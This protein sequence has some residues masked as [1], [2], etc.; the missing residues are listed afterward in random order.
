MSNGLETCLYW[1]NKVSALSDDRGMAAI[2]VVYHPYEAYWKAEAS[3]SDCTQL[4]YCADYAPEA[5][6]G[7]LKKIM[8]FARELN[9]DS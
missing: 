4:Q 8:E 1:A 3:W 9:A 6:D 5:I 7:L 2:K